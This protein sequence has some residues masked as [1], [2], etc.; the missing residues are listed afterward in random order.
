MLLSAG[1][2]GWA[3]QVCA[4]DPVEETCARESEGNTRL[5]FGVGSKVHSIG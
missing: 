4:G 3:V 2:L 5:S 1:C